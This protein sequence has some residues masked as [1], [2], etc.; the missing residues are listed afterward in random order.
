MIKIQCSCGK[1]FNIPEKYRGKQG[2]C[3]QC[4]TIIVVPKEDE[5]IPLF[6]EAAETI[7][8]S[9]NAQDLFERAIDTVV[10]ISDDGRLYG[11]GVI[12]DDCG[13]IVTNRH[14]VG[15]A[16]KV[17]VRLNSG[18]EYIGELLASYKDVDLAFIRIPLKTENFVPLSR[19]AVLKIGQTLYAI[20]HPLGLQNTITRGI[21]SALN[22]E[23]NGMNYIQTDASIN[24]GNS[25]GPLFNEQAELVGINTMVIQATQG[26]GFA[27]PNEIA[28][29]RYTQIQQEMTAIYDY[30]YCGICGNNSGNRRFCEHCGV[31]LD[32][33]QPL[34]RMNPR[35]LQQMQPVSF[36]LTECKICKTGI[37]PDEKYCSFCGTTIVK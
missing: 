32:S 29:E 8:Q 24:P 14:V 25:G 1:S 11:S 30:E 12:V 4:S 7:K 23:I 5:E 3:P 20:G 19:E 35:L 21:V 22:R 17:K 34:T 27:I 6:I 28:F 15:I 13:G 9:Y 18:E 36:L 10:G 16:S 33:R 37:Y 31:E 26:L 2:R